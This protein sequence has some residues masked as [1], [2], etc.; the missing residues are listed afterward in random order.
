M[1]DGLTLTTRPGSGVAPMFSGPWIGASYAVDVVFEPLRDPRQVV[2]I[3]EVGVREGGED[4]V[5]EGKQRLLVVD[6]DP[7]LALEVDRVDRRGRRDLVDERRRPTGLR[8]ELEAHPGLAGDPPAQMLERR[9]LAEA[10]RVDEAHRPRLQAEHVVQGTAGLAQREVERRGLK[11]PVAHAQGQLPLRRLRP[12]LE[13]REVV[14]EAPDRPLARQRQRGARFVQRAP[15]LFVDRDVLAEP[16]GSG[17]GEPHVGRHAL[18][19]VGRNGVESLVLA[20]LDDERQRGDDR[21][22][23]VRRWAR[24]AHPNDEGPSWSAGVP[25][26]ALRTRSCSSLRSRSFS[27]RKIF[28]L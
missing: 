21:P 23:R 11:R 7:V 27:L 26:G 12:Q 15:V 6:L 28:G 25:G 20:R 3:L 19:V 18:E 22:Q 1:R 10:Q 13:R 2:R 5:V 4:V 9:L 8:I 17:A 24:G 14:A 16:V